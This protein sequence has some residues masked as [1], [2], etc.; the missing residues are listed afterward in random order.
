MKPWD[1]RNK[2]AEQL[3]GIIEESQF[4]AP[5]A[6]D[7]HYRGI[8]EGYR[9]SLDAAVAAGQITAGDN[10]V[11]AWALMGMNVF[12]GLRF[13]QWDETRDPAEVARAA[14]EMIADGLRASKPD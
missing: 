9:A 3:Y 7:D 13:G 8:A 6:H 2:E 5:D 4:V 12:L 14:A 1:D 11:R 10:E